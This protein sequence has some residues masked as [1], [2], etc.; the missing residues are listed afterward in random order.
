MDASSEYKA[1]SQLAVELL[2]AEMV[3]VIQRERKKGRAQK[4]IRRKN[5]RRKNIRTQLLL[6]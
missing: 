2:S 3:I 1:F 4:T 5:R 6:I